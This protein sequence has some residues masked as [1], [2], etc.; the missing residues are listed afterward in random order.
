MKFLWVMLGIVTNLSAVEGFPFPLPTGAVAPAAVACLQPAALGPADRIVSAGADGFRTSDHRRVRFVGVNITAGDAFPEPEQGRRVA[1]RLASFGINLVRLHHLDAPWG[2]PNIFMPEMTYGKSTTGALAPDSVARLTSFIQALGEHGVYVDLNLKVTRQFSIADGF[3]TD[4]ADKI[5]G[6]FDPRAIALQQDY[7]TKLF[8]AVGSPANLALVEVNNEDAI[9]FNPEGLVDLPTVYQ[10]QLRV[11]YGKHLQTT[12]RSTEATFAAWNRGCEP[13]GADLLSASTWSLEQHPS[14]SATMSETADQVHVAD[15]VPDAVE[16]HLQLH[17][18]PLSLVPGR[19]Y[20]LTYRVRSD[21]ERGYSVNLGQAG[22]PWRMLGLSEW[23]LAGPAWR[24]QRFAFTATDAQGVP[25]RLNFIVGGGD[26]SLEFAEVRL[27]PGDCM[28]PD[29][30]QRVEDGSMRLPRLTNDGPG[31][32]LARTVMGLEGEYRDRLTAHLRKLGVSAPITISQAS[33]GG[34]TGLA[35]EAATDWIDNHNYWEHPSFPNKSWDV[36][37]YRMHDRS[38]LTAP[39][40]GALESGLWRVAGKPFTLS[41]YYHPAPNSYNAE[42]VPLALATAATQD[43]DGVFL[44]AHNSAESPQDCIT[45]FFDSGHHPA[46]MALLPTM[47]RIY[48]TGAIAPFAGSATLTVPQDRLAEFATRGDWLRN[49]AEVD[50]GELLRRR[51]Q[52]RLVPSGPLALTVEGPAGSDQ[53][54][55][56]R[57]PAGRERQIIN[58]P[59]AAVLVGFLGGE[60]IAIGACRVQG[61][62]FAAIAIESRDGKPIEQSRRL[63]ISAVGSANNAS[64]QWN[65]DHTTATDSWKSGPPVVSTPDLRITLAG[66]DSAQVTPVQG[67][68][69]IPTVRSQNGLTLSLSAQQ[70]TI[71]WLVER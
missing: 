38:M 48:R 11:A 14:A 61:S 44:F 43:W 62:G 30:S 67:H 58:L 7:A 23:V 57:L 27:M 10:E 28:V 68:G 34:A 55:H 66:W 29:A 21:K 70:Q 6:Y 2:T 65:A 63:L 9:L 22:A 24:N 45:G 59:Q 15:I 47:A 26:S 19:R 42:T 25:A 54:Q 40:A 5:V 31:R 71:W 35:R 49:V 32:D 41:E 53:V 8:A 13:L 20:T 39:G 51:W 17:R 37:D 16:W 1:A 69:A 33:W 60:P 52:L 12:Y 3:S 64:L 56:R 18:Q 46:V 50:E 4:G 36:D